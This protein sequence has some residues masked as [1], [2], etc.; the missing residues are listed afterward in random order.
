ML[1]NILKLFGLDIAAKIEAVKASFELRVEQAT[2]HVKQVAQQ[3]A[4]I[5][6][7]PAF[8]TITATMA[9]GIVSGASI[10]AGK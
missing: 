8:A 9:A 1:F 4:I 3:A 2:D 6:V 5:G 7:L 10:L